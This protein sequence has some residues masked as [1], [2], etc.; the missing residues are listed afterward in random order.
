MI[1][2]VIP[3]LDSG[4][5]II[6]EEIPIDQNETLQSLTNKVHVVEHRLVVTAIKKILLL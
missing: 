1:H 4:E 5:V 2:K 6:S 3:D